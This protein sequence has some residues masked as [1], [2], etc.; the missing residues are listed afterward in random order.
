MLVD[1]VRDVCGVVERV[2][3]AAVDGGVYKVFD[4]VSECGVYEIFALVF[5]DFGV[6]AE[7]SDLLFS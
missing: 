2:V 3:A 5:F 1:E 7:G 4:V 6:S